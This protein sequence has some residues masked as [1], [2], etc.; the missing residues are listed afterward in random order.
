[1]VFVFCVKEWM[2]FISKPTCLHNFTL[3]HKRP[4]VVFTFVVLNVFVLGFGVD[5]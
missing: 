3:L 1:M 4:K 2:H 5:F